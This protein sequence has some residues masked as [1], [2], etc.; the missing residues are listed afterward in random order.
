MAGRSRQFVHAFTK[1]KTSA[2]HIS[3]E[4]RFSAINYPIPARSFACFTSGIAS[5]AAFNIGSAAFCASE[6]PVKKVETHK[7]AEIGERFSYW[8]YFGVKTLSSCRPR[9]QGERY[10]NIVSNEDFGGWKI[11][12]GS[13]K[14]GCRFLSCLKF[15]CYVIAFFLLQFVGAGERK[16]AILG[17][18]AVNVYAIGLYVEPVA[19]KVMRNAQSTPL[20][21]S[22]L[23]G[24]T[25]W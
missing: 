16:K 24:L 19:S 23:L 12:D 7:D 3:R 5:I 11:F 18:I 15:P 21:R 2:E 1:F 13:S 25:A 14:C 17:P 10:W 8:I 22:S 20:P 4:L 9:F 6:N